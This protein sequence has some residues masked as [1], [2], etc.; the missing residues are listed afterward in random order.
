[1]KKRSTII[2][3]C[4]LASCCKEDSIEVITP[5]VSDCQEL[6]IT[7]FQGWNYIVDSAF[8]L[9]PCFNP[10]DAT[11]I[12]FTHRKYGNGLTKLYRYDLTTHTKTLLHTGNQIF[13]P[14]W[15]S[16]DWILMNLT[17][18]SVWKIKSDGTDITQLTNTGND[19]YP[20]WRSDCS[21]F[22][23]H[24]GPF[25]DN[26]QKTIL[27]TPDAIPFDTLQNT[28]LGSNC[29]WRQD[30]LACGMGGDGPKVSDI[31]N[32]TIVFFDSYQNNFSGGSTW[33]N[34]TEFI[35]SYEKGIYKSNYLTGEKVLIKASCRTR[36]YLDPTYHSNVD[37]IIWTR[38]DLNQLNDFDIEVKSRLF[39]MNLDGSEETEIII[40]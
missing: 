8:Y 7:P 13:A 4:L 21:M 37:K 35:W 28:G 18:N 11:E 9:Y 32:D 27:Y 15:G 5:V 24:R 30:G 40:E 14:D 36:L 2:L 3:L 38:V 34:A 23:A 22:S 29:S 33:L 20:I 1:M 16:N 6:G 25:V 31:T 12:I 10:N 26:L 17:G 39:I 19:F